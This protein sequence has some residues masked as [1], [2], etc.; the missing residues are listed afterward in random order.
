MKQLVILG[1]AAILLAGCA[2]STIE[3]RK[4]E[5]YTAYSE[6]TPEQRSAVDAGQIKV[7]MPK[8]AVYIAW[9]KPYQVLNSESAAGRNEV[10]LYVGTYLQGYSYWGFRP[11][12]GPY[13]YYHSPYLYYDYLP[14]SYPTAEVVFE[15]EAVKQWR[16]LPGP[17]PWY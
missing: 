17:W 7:G 14:V 13:H 1:L 9:G 15:K 3:S 5:R 2:T 11:Y 10:W 6:L 4:K 12:C 8:D 16:T